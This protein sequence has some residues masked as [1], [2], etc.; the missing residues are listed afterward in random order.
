MPSGTCARC[1]AQRGWL[2]KHHLKLQCEGGTDA[3]GT[4]L[5]CANCHED[6]HEGPMGGK[7]VAHRR[8][9]PEVNARRSE[10]MRKQWQDP[11]ARARMLADRRPRTSPTAAERLAQSERM[12]AR[13]ADPDDPIH[14]SQDPKVASERMK[15]RWTNPVDPLRVSQDQIDSLIRELRETGMTLEEIMTE[16]SC[17]RHTVA[18]S[19]KRT[20]G[21]PSSRSVSQQ[22]RRA[23]EKQLNS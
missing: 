13:W 15:A 2:H 9:N 16:I 10:A 4:E 21:D 5:V 14:E 8:H 1:G 22:K 12:K 3:D 17:S 11:E 6:I 19:L 20:G 7:S 23:R 18:R